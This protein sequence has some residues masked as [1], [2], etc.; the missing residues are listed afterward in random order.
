MKIEIVEETH[1]DKKSLKML[2]FGNKN[3]APN[4]FYLNQPF[5]VAEGF[6]SKKI[7]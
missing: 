3:V 2:I 1:R 5:I 6:S 7:K 4:E